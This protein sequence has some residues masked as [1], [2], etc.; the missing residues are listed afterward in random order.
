MPNT[1]VFDLGDVLFTWN[2]PSSVPLIP[3]KVLHCMLKSPTW[4]SYEVAAFSE[5]EAYTKLSEEFDVP[6][7]TIKDAFQLSRDTLKSDSA[8]LDLIRRIRMQLGWKVYAM[9]NISAPDWEVLATKATKE[10]WALFDRVFTSLVS[11]LLSTHLLLYDTTILLSK[12]RRACS[13]TRCQVLR[14]CHR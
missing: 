5:T 3:P 4:S 14:N 13:Q 12:S 6:F 9:S 2:P 8:M 7:E 10:E 1:I 11:F